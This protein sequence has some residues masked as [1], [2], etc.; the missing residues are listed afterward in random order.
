MSLS[1]KRRQ[2]WPTLLRRFAGRFASV[3]RVTGRAAMAISDREL[4]MLGEFV[5]R[6]IKPLQDR[7]AALEAAN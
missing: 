4:E 2:R 6:V 5:G 1:L 7:I 3:G